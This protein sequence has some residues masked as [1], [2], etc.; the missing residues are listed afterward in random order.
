MPDAFTDIQS[1]DSA[2][3]D[4]W[5]ILTPNHRTAVQVHESYGAHLKQQSQIKVRYSPGIFPVDI[6]MKNIYQELFFNEENVQLNTVLESYQELNLWKKIIGESNFSSP[7]LNLENSA[8]KVLEAYRL[9]IQW[10]ISFKSLEAYQS[11]IGDSLYLDDC[12]AFLHWAKQYQSYCHKENLISFSELLKSLLPYIE[13]NDFVLPKKIILLGFTAPPPLYQKL[14]SILENRL[15]IKRLQW[16]EMTPTVQKQSFIDDAS[17]IKAAAKWSKE[18]LESNSEAKI[19][20][21][22]NELSSQHSLFQRVFKA[23]FPHQKENNAAFF[24]ASGIN[25]T[26]KYP[27]FLGIPEL[28]MLNQEELS[29]SD[30]CH[31]LRSPLLLAQ[32]EEDA[33]A[34]LEQY[35]RNNRQSSIRSAHLRDLLNYNERGWYSPLLAQA[36]Q[37]CENL[38]RQQNFQQSIQAWA[39]FFSKQLEILAWPDNQAQ[40]HQQ[41]LVSCW[42]QVLG[43]FKKLGFLYETLSFKQAHNLLKQ[44]INNYSHSDNRQEAPIQLLSPH[45]TRGLRFTHIWF[46]GL[47]DLQ[48]PIKQYPNPFIPI[49][50]QRIVQLP[51]SS[52]E[53]AHEAA[54]N[55]LLKIQANTSDQLVLSFPQTNTDGELQPTP[56]ISLL[57]NKTN[58]TNNLNKEISLQLHPLSL[59]NYLDAIK[60][61]TTET[62]N[63]K[64][65][66]KIADTE[67]LKGGI[68]LISNQA[69]CPFRAFSIHR[70]KAKELQEFSYGIPAIDLGSTIHLIL[71]QLWAKLKTQDSI[72]SLPSVKLEKLIEV[73]CET[74]LEFLRK[75]H[76]HFFKPAYAAL[77]KKR[78]TNLMLKWLEQENL[79]SAF[80][81][82][83]QEFN[84]QWKYAELTLDFKID[85]IDKI[86]N[87]YALVDY[88]SGSGKPRISADTRPSDPQLLLYSDALAQ[89]DIFGPVNALLY[90]QVNIASLSYQGISLNNETYPKIGLSEQRQFAEYSSWEELK[91][92][93]HLVLNKLAQE[94]LD[95]FVAVAPKGASS[96]QYCHLSS[97]CRIQEKNQSDQSISYD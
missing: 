92:H 4:S 29:S 81:V 64:A 70:L 59:E 11:K 67:I 6:W 34:A 16:Q 69:E 5:V 7:L 51:E 27:M 91:Q 19:G 52:P 50:L 97:F 53:L 30:L 2:L 25:L 75:K 37:Q 48:W 96:C 79:R 95:G 68:S 71:E 63:E 89:K 86:E 28:L 56:L 74:G 42:N 12:T 77:E 10:Q 24:I 49:S 88:K 41:F 1:L 55:I 33:R 90:A 61:K 65:Y 22:S 8:E 36:L 31:I 14:F 58:F 72:S 85:R 21:I 32:E 54:K 17:E 73:A 80:E 62:L 60:I 93:W 23:T 18:I 76:S 3:K 78:L 43:N 94:F 83:E 20:I 47:S 26:N 45:D 40:Q 39:E 15:E 84:V 57:G 38:R 13:T 87:G 66:L 46:M 44:L 82:L 9:L 35:L